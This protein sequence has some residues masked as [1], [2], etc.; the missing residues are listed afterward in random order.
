MRKFSKRV[1]PRES[2]ENFTRYRYYSV[3][4][5]ST[6]NCDVVISDCYIIIGD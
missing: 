3:H 2:G 4:R 1:S 6:L 5:V